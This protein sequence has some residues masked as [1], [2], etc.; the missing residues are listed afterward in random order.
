MTKSTVACPAAM[1]AS[2]MSLPTSASVRPGL[3]HCGTWAWTAS[4][5]APAARSAATSAGRLAHAQLAQDL[6]ARALVGAGH[7][8]AQGEDL[9]RPHVV[10]EGDRGRLRGSSRATSA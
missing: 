1:I 3:S 7:R 6:A 8:V 4:I 10:V 5:A 2:A 9:G